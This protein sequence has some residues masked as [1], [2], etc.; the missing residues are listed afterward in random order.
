MKSICLL[1]AASAIAASAQDA[2]PSYESLRQE[3]RQAIARG[4]S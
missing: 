4:N 3:I 2:K 1:L